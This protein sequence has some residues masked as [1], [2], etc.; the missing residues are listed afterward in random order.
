M[1]FGKKRVEEPPHPRKEPKFPGPLTARAV[2]DAF[3]ET[4]DFVHRQAFVGGDP[5]CKADVFFIDGLTAGNVISETV[6]RPL[7][8]SPMLQGDVSLD[9]R[10]EYIENGSVYSAVVTRR[11]TVD[12]VATD[13][14]NGFC[15]ILLEAKKL[16]FS[17]EVKTPEKRSISTPEVESV[18]K[19]AKDGLVETMR[20][21]TSLVRR[22]IRTPDLRFD[23]LVVGRQTLTAISVVYVKG[24]TNP[25][26]VQ[27]TIR[28]LNEIDEDGVLSPAEIET[29]LTDRVKTPFPLL[30]YT[31]RTDNFCSGLLDGRVG[32][33][34]DGL[35]IGYLLPGTFA[36][37]M[38]APQDRSSN[39][40]QATALRVIRYAALCISLFLPGFYIAVATF[41]QEMVPTALLRSII[42]SKKDVP[43][44]TIF[45]VLGLLVAFE[46]L[47]EA[48]LRLPKTIGQTVSIIGGLVVGQA[49]VD[50]KIISPVIVIVVAVTGI[51]GY[52]LPNQDFAGAM[53]ICR[54]II[55]V[56]SAI[57][58]LFGTT[59]AGLLLLY[60]LASLESFGV[61]YLTPFAP[62][63]NGNEGAS[64]IKQPP[65]RNIKY[66]ESALKP[67]NIR[68]R[69]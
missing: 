44:P 6:L 42:E 55:A 69:K 9:K 57:L 24:L 34:V 10:V 60:H 7:V 30:I 39:Y 28:R 54:F 11:E 56:A 1:L 5:K 45:E 53:R 26:I 31:E 62:K 23:Q 66:R 52:T 35:P 4:G 27:E 8:Q 15:V 29:Y 40:W 61:P 19:G 38:S 48:G 50:A 33:L 3:G 32:V 51:S 47:Q 25:D 22:H 46:I 17:F 68:R 65:M 14:T 67:Q 13:L 18:V 36:Q 64:T 37:F 16:A 2:C 58:G 43:F 41:H 12:D 21:N 63:M 49:A 20:T 59:V